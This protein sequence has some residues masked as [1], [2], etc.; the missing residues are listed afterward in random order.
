MFSDIK[1]HIRDL[2]PKKFQVPVK[3]W[4]GRFSGSLEEE[5]S[6]LALIVR[7]NDLV[8]DVGG[9][10]GIY[11]YPL[12][13]R[14][15]VVEV[16]E[17]NP[18]CFDILLTWAKNKRNVHLHSVALSSG[19][20][21]ASLHIPV[22]ES[23]LEHDASASIEHGGFE[24]TRDQLVPL[25]TLDSFDFKN[26]SLIKIDVEGHEYSVIEGSSAT[27]T[28]SKPALLIEIEERHNSRPIQE[29]FNKILSFGY[30]GYFMTAGKLTSLDGFDA[31]RDQSMDSFD[32][33]N[34][35]YI[36]NFLFLHCDRLNMGEYTK[37][38][39]GQLK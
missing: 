34:C 29:V 12:W 2:L 37:L 33:P 23:G 36:N 21:S 19:E 20:G 32:D 7:K 22:D 6:L 4:Y 35:P 26:V 11:S 24:H 39:S 8:I 18:I 28:S 15:A 5:M 16:F 25:K 3:Y 17:P 9:N 10:R 1:T 31:D 14:G 38:I 27:I 13:K 30:L